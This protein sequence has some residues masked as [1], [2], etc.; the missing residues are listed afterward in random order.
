MSFFDRFRKKTSQAPAS[1]YDRLSAL[2]DS[3][4][5]WDA[6]SNET[7]KQLVIVKCVEYG[8]TQDVSRIPRLFALYG[9]AKTRLDTSQRMELLTQFAAMTEERMGQGHMGLM[10]FLAVDDDASI[11]STAAMSLAVLFDSHDG[12]ELA[13][14]T[15]VVRTLLSR[16][17]DPRTQGRALGGIL[18]L[19]DKRLLPLLEDAWSRLSDDS[20]LELTRA[21]SGFVSE[22]MVEFWLRCLEGG[23]SE[24]VF[25]SVVAAI[26]KM[27]VIAQVPFVLDV[28]RV[29]PAYLDS[30]NPMRV[31]RKRS[32]GEYLEEIL[33]RL[34]ALEE[35]ESDPKLIPKI[36]EVWQNPEQ[37]RGII[38]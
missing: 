18:L 5:G 36:Y 8:V 1:D 11:C 30:E 2:G 23:C 9:Y 32:F 4:A 25:G 14:P 15:F 29:M 21:K 22:A 19:G 27:P 24:A 35:S 13:G 7:L 17:K 26:A 10:M 31:L 12:D 6:L 38:G 28:Q 16:E 34:D 3:P 20:R 37:F 33:P